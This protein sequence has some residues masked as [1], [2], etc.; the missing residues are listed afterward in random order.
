MNALQCAIKKVSGGYILKSEDIG[1]SSDVCS[2][3]KNDVGIMLSGGKGP[4]WTI[5]KPDLLLCNYTGC[6]V[7]AK[8]WEAVSRM[9][10][11]P[12]VFLDI[13][14]AGDGITENGMKYV[15]GQ[16]KELIKVCENITDRKYDED[17]LSEM[18]EVSRQA[19]DLWVKIL[20]SAK[21]HPSPI[22]A[23]FEAVSFM[24]PIYVLR[25]TE[26]LLD[27]YEKA[28]AEIEERISLGIGPVPEERF[29]VVMEG[30]PCWSHF[31]AFW[32]LLKKWGVVNVASTYT[33]VGGVWDFGFRHDPE[34]PLESI[35][36][37]LYGNNDYLG[38]GPRSEML[39]H[40]VKEYQ[41][42]GMII[43]SVKS[44]RAYSM[45][46]GA[47]REEFIQNR[48][49]P[50]LH[51]ES[52]IADPRYFQEAQLRNRIDAFFELLDH[53]KATGKGEVG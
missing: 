48:G 12:I 25:G 3:M 53:R 51:I 46:Q 4:E 28:W 19:E 50:T 20:E 6:T 34:R 41:A 38:I 37:F 10:D 17:R 14:F 24:A 47:I 30:V 15:M 39:D 49:L 18:L 33:K 32:G 21:N 52:D 36:E 11:V 1:H 13:P 2:Y 40:Y 29:R 35:A 5:P 7:Y 22:D 44:C 16:I 9:Y 8:W 31:T 27:Y 23:F 42:D 43:H 26:E 45:G